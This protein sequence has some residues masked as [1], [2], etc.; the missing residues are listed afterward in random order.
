M[1]A[2]FEKNNLKIYILLR[3]VLK[4]VLHL[5]FNTGGMGKNLLFLLFGCVSFSAIAQVPFSAQNFVANQSIYKQIDS[6][7]YD[8]KT[9]VVIDTFSVSI[10]PPQYSLKIDA[11]TFISPATTSSIQVSE[12][13]R[14]VYPMVVQ[15][16]TEEVLAPQGVRLVSKENV[17]TNDNKEG[18]LVLVSMK[19][20]TMDFYRMML[21]TG[22]YI[23]TIWVTANYPVILKDKVEAILRKSILSI[24]F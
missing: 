3:M 20:D 2:I 12:L 18:I 17:M 19:V 1:D 4:I 11:R 22:D 16:I 24:K 5:N 9:T 7:I 23:K 14:V 15:N 10:I 13:K 21:F 6:L 8:G